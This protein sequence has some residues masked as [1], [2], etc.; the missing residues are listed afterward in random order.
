MSVDINAFDSVLRKI[1]NHMFQRFGK[2][3]MLNFLSLSREFFNNAIWKRFRF[4]QSEFKEDIDLITENKITFYDFLKIS[5]YLL[6]KFGESE[7]I[8]YEYGHYSIANFLDHLFKW[9][10]MTDI[11]E[12]HGFKIPEISE[13]NKEVKKFFKE[14]VDNEFSFEEIDEYI[15]NIDL[16]DMIPKKEYYKIYKNIKKF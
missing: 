11:A 1:D 4:S 8:V 7:D 15:K 10:R 13:I 16:K 12:N 14:N 3:E 5:V 2:H 9:S 6:H